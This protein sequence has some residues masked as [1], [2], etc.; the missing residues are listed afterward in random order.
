MTAR[1][2]RPREGSAVRASQ[3]SGPSS[4][5]V[6]VPC[7]NGAP[8]LAQTLRSALAQ[9]A[10]PAE[11][12]VVDDG[13][14]DG[15]AGI[16]ESF[17]PDVKVVSG[18]Q[19]GAAVARAT[20]A[21]HAGGAR[22]MFLDADDLLTPGTLAALGAA[23]DG[24]PNAGLALCPWDRFERIGSDP[25][26]PWIVA[27]PSNAL[28][29]PGQDRLAAWL[30]GTWSP[31]CCVLW[32][33]VGFEASGG[34]WQGAGLDDDGNLVRRALA[35]GVIPC[36]ARGGLALYRRLPSDGQSYS[37]RRRDRWG[38]EVRLA[39]LADTVAS[40]EAHGRVARYRGALS[41]ALDD[42][43]LDAA[44]YDGLTADVAALN[45]RIGR[46]GRLAR[47]RRSVGR[48]LARADAW[49][50]ERWSPTRLAR[51]DVAPSSANLTVDHPTVGVV[52]PTFDRGPLVERAVRSVLAQSYAKLDVVVVD[53]GSRDDTVARLEAIGDARL[54]VVSREN[55]GV[56][57]ARNTGLASVRGEYVAL[58]DSDDW[59]HPA[60]IERQVAALQAAPRRVGFCYTGIEFRAQDAEPRRREA[61]VTGDCLDG[62][63]VTNPVHAP[64]S[65]GLVRRA[66]IDVVGGFDP[67]LP[68]IE[69]W[70]WLQRVGRLFHITA[71][72]EPLTYYADDR[73][74]DRRS[75][76]FRANMDARAM[77]WERN[78]H[79][80]RRIGAAHVF[81]L[82]SARRELREP[83]GD[84][85]KG[86]R[87]VRQALYERPQRIETWPWL[88][89]MMAHD[90][91]RAWMRDRGQSI[92]ARRRAQLAN[93]VLPD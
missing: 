64:T 87:L 84:P 35:R 31:P 88:G 46:E 73:R 9:T 70:D 32:T 76:A 47:P 62:L 75:R 16:A 11:V 45:A 14:T 38:V 59:W 21:R 7:R 39:S 4:V 25:A 51:H 43:A 33:R 57:R 85:R 81:L 41:E 65:S 23:L 10:P 61:T 28:P 42:I 6:V 8:F 1:D 92:H 44:R 63:L 13:S 71:V 29:R 67:G 40:L 55:G 26:A 90:D 50:R 91:M 66:V 24:A 69:D 34:W 78:R 68:A 79:A 93:R 12:I 58:L 52:I 74:E 48:M 18:A 56:A 89:Y 22:L 82:E 60:K 72:N 83:E 2:V 30:T 37:S 54:R 49:V 3:W 53:D 27:A 17:G 86:R 15:S 20:G 5:S 80:L 36:D 19:E 77:L